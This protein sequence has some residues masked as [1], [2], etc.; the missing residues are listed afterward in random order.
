MRNY[1]FYVYML[2]NK[3][4]TVLY[5]GVTNNLKRR[6]SEHK[7]KANSGFTATYNANKLVHYEVFSD[8]RVAIKREKQ[9]KG[10][11]R[12]KKNTLVNFHNPGWEDLYGKL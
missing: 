2:T 8:I 12:S 5:L 10:W 1:V 7:C 6:V 11:L 9:L 3:Y 4:N